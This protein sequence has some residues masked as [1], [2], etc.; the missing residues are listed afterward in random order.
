MSFRSTIG[1]TT[2]KARRAVRLKLVRPAAT[3]ASASEQI[4]RSTANSARTSTESR[5]CSASRSVTERG[6]IVCSVAAAAAPMTRKPPAWSR[7]WW[8]VAMKTRHGGPV[9]SCRRRAR[10]TSSSCPRPTQTH[11][12]TI[13]VARLARKRAP[14]ISGWPGNAT[15]VLT[16]TTGLMA[17][18]ASRNAR[19]AAGTTPRDISRPAMGTEPHSQ[20]GSTTPAEAATGTARAGWRGM[21][22]GRRSGG[23]KAAIAPLMITPSTRKGRAWKAMATKI[24]VQ[25]STASWVR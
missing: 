16:R 2:R 20:P 23:T 21:S 24:V 5:P 25:F 13:A 7:S 6:T 11:P 14:T 8:H 22:R 10:S 3:N 1:P 4:D 19:A 12:T 18:A 9:C 17:G 15:A